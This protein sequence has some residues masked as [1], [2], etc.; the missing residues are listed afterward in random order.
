MS[1]F[2]LRDERLVSHTTRARERSWVM[3][4]QGSKESLAVYSRLVRRFHTIFSRP[5]GVPRST[6]WITVK[7]RSE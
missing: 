4:G 3:V 6:A 5:R 1:D 2:V 7:V